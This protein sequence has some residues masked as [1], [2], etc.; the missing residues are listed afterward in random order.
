MSESEDDLILSEGKVYWNRS[1][2][3]LEIHFSEEET[4]VGRI[5]EHPVYFWETQD[6]RVMKVEVKNINFH[7]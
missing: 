7:Y 6:G 4:P 5:H 1:K 2:D 3:S